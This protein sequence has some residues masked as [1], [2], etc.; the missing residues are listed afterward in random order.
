MFII[1]V[2]SHAVTPI[3]HRLLVTPD[4]VLGQRCVCSA[5]QEAA[6]VPPTFVVRV[7]VKIPAKIEAN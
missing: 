6:I 2:H 3:V 5:A 1:Q 7:V 4:A